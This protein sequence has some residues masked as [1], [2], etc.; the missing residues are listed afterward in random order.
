MTDTL[1][2]VSSMAC[3]P[4]A[5]LSEDRLEAFASLGQGILYLRW[6][7]FVY[8]PP[9]QTVCL[10]FAKLLSQHLL[11]SA[12]DQVPQLAKSE[13]LVRLDI[14]EQQWFVL[15][16]HYTQRDF[17]RTK[18]RSVDGLVS[19]LCSFGFQSNHRLQKG[20]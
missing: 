19:S 4:A 20:A 9:N 6:N 7:Y 10:Q 2:V 15:S 11:T 14:I 18:N 1:S 13:Y 8:L 12:A 5:H 17:Y 3:A 16:A